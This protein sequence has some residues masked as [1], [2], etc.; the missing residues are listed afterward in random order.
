MASPTDLKQGTVVQILSTENVVQRFPELVGKFATIDKVPVYPSTWFTVRILQQPAR[1]V[2]M[3]PT[4]LK[5][6]PNSPSMNSN[7]ENVPVKNRCAG[8]NFISPSIFLTSSTI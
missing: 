4:A 6:A 1:T 7:E 2:K 8:C 3:Q 5:L